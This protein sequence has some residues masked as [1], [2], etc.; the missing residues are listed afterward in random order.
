MAFDKKPS[1]GS[2]EELDA[3]GVWVKS[4]PQDL[5]AGF[6]DVARFDTEFDTRTNRFDTEAL[7]YQA[8]FDTEYDDLDVS[9]DDDEMTDIDSFDDTAMLGVAAGAGRSHAGGTEEVSTQLLMKIAD[10][11]SM[12]RSELSTLKKEFIDI[13]SDGGSSVKEETQHGGFFDEEGDE[14]I[15]L[16]GDEME[17][18]L[19]STSFS[20]DPLREADE[21]ALRE[22]SEKADFASDDDDDMEMDFENLGIGLEDEDEAQDLSDDDDFEAFPLVDF[23]TEFEEEDI[24]ELTEELI[25][26]ELVEE[27]EELRDIRLEGVDPLTPAPE[28]S[29]YLEG[30]PFAQEDTSIE[31]TLKDPLFGDISDEAAA[32]SDEPL[33][34]DTL[35]DTLDDDANDDDIMAISLDEDGLDLNDLNVEEL[36]DDFNTDDMEPLGLELEEESVDIEEPIDTIDSIDTIDTGSTDLSA[37]ATLTDVSEDISF[38][39]VLSLDDEDLALDMD[40][41]C[42]DV[43]LDATESV[44][45][46][47]D[48]EAG[49][50]LEIQDDGFEIGDD[51]ASDDFAKDDDVK[52][53]VKIDSKDDDRAQE[54]I[55]EGFEVNAEEAAV[56]F[57]D[58]LEA[59]DEE[60][61]A[62][63][64]EEKDINQPETVT[65]APEQSK[66]TVP[67]V[68]DQDISPSLR[69]E[70]KN[71]LSYMDHL[72]EALP[73]EKIEEFA[74]S[75]YFETYKKIFKELGLV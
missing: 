41:F 8:G 47:S 42:A 4:E 58:D 31:D 71:V 44:F 66:N 29:I 50:E 1:V 73:E 43:G 24:H 10:E 53:S 55:P 57:D 33:L 48:F 28:D 12:I 20:D 2:A 27:T 25:A 19:T 64:E 63:K 16:T 65:K 45:E 61:L 26:S 62:V 40:N 11:L 5:T 23:Q 75:D 49:I 36:E 38:E 22:L 46:D 56:S 9:N 37:S 52:D 6:P 69:K 39:D 30:D 7:P 13:R 72:L 3:Y 70:L 59:F 17:H 60:D 67:A 54:V 32:L 74:K 14:T 21:A 15:A 68:N 18:I 35:D 34:D 51:L